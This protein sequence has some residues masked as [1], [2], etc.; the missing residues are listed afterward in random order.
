MEYNSLKPRT[1][2]L[3][4]GDARNQNYDDLEDLCQNIHHFDKHCDIIIN[5]PSVN[6]PNVKLRHIVQPVNVSPFIFGVFTEFLK[7]IK[8]NPM[9]FDHVCLF[10]AN[11]YMINDFVPE[12][13]VNYLQFYNC[14]NWDFKY[15]GKDFSN[16][17]IG[18]PLI[19]YDT[20]NWDQKGMNEILEIPNAMISNWE[21]AYL[22]KETIE[23]CQR[24]LKDCENIYPNRDCIQLFP[25]Y[26]ALKTG[27][28]WMFTPFF[29]TFDPSNK[30]NNHNH[31]ITKEQINEKHQEGYAFVKRV[32]YNKDCQL[33]E[34]IRRTIVL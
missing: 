30:K 22:T 14:P 2:Y 3:I 5:H 1:L 7:Y 9:N 16:I 19:Q 15:T 27:Q 29:G 31:I 33:K 4:F 28:P 6:H 8:E 18:N 20:F 12:M 10:S 34:F 23:L 17:T 26:M 32:G 11:Q 25:G 24:H 21:A 13:G